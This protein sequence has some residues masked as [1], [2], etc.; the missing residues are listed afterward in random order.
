MHNETL[1][2]DPEITG[3]TADSRNVAPGYLF[4]ALPGARADGRSFIASALSRGAAAILAPPG[5]ALPDGANDNTVPL[6]VD[7]DPRRRLALLA[8]RFFGAQPRVAA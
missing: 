3:L 4:A 6:I 8:A 1:R 2:L 7:D 5:T